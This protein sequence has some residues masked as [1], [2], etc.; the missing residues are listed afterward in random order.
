MKDANV[1]IDV[2]L[3]KIITSTRMSAPPH[4]GLYLLDIQVN[5]SPYVQRSKD[6]R[7]LEIKQTKE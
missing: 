3:E 7:V 4:A 5:F 1:A 2:K 6:N